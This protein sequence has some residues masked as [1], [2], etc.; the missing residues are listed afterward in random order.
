M[1]PTKGAPPGDGGISGHFRQLQMC[2][3]FKIEDACQ[4]V[5]SADLAIRRTGLYDEVPEDCAN[6]PGFQRN[7]FGPGPKN[8]ALDLLNRLPKFP[9][10]LSA[11]VGW[12]NIGW[13]N[14]T[15][16]WSVFCPPFFW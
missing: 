9:N 6:V 3:D 1:T 12:S 13:G 10:S 5:L 15:D 4:D 2:L 8:L 16:Q 11:F 14:P 7:H